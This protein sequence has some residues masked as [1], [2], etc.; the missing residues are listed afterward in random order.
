MRLTLLLWIAG[1]IGS[2]DTQT[3]PDNISIERDI[4]YAT[5]DGRDLKLDVYW[6]ADTAKPLPLIVFVHG[7]AW[8][9]GDKANARARV[10]LSRGYAV[11]S[12]N[13]RLSHEAIFPAQI[14]D[15]KAAVRWLRA[16]ASRFNV[17]PDRFGAWGPSAGG[18]LV[19]LLG[20][21]G[22]VA[23]LEGDLGNTDVSSRVQAVC[24][25]FGPTDFL[26]MND[27]EGNIDHNAPDSPES[28]LVGGP[29]QDHPDRVAR[30]NPITYVS[31][32]DPPFLM[33]HGSNDRLVI[34]NQSEL[35]HDALQQT[36]VSSNLIVI[37]D[38]GHGLNR[39]DR[40]A[41][42]LYRLV[43][44]FFDREL[45][46]RKSDWVSHDNNTHPWVTDFGRNAPGSHDV[47]IYSDL[48]QGYYG[49]TVYL[50]PSYGDTTRSFPAVY[51]LHGRG[52]NPHSANRFI[53]R[54][55]RSIEA[56][57]CPEMV[58]ISPTGTRGSMYVDAPDG[59][60]PVESIIVT[61]LIPHVEST[62][63]VL[64]SRDGRAIDGFS[65]G[66]FGAA[67]IGFK[68]PELFGTI[69]LM[70]SAIH[71]PPFLRDERSDIFAA[72]FGGDL[73]YAERE[74]PWTLVRQNAD[75]L[76]GRTLMRLYVGENDHRLR[77]KNKEFS[78][79]MN[80]LGLEHEF[81]IVP[82]AAHNMAQ[83]VDGIGDA[84]WTYYAKAFGM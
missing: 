64:A 33:M 80:E 71:R 39:K 12:I 34:Q 43:E 68:H 28:K 36:G 9:R 60:G 81:G 25:W 73:E 51:W 59:T 79:L 23:D 40:N 47:L 70:G 54:A 4:P 32:D 62:Y 7:G 11:A 8:R 66:G 1:M 83:V 20:T 2:A 46:D 31:D 13:Y 61:E 5:V 30:A 18:H 26:R 38:Q 57:L 42:H 17:D 14:H 19:A 67:H 16:N 76:R 48:V 75:A 41:E 27:V 72:A 84:A 45:K 78:A 44:A 21:S 56:G 53:Q 77:E 10:L 49:Y 3:L 24:D 69:S 50:P 82:E 74:S 65:M 29:I 52:G 35:L 6:H 55:H 15:C 58:I 63:R 37:D 22:D